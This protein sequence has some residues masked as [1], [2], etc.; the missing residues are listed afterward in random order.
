MKGGMLDIKPRI[1]IVDEESIMV[2]VCSK[3][4]CE[5][6]YETYTAL[7]SEEALKFLSMKSVDLVITGVNQIIMSGL[8]L[9]KIIREKYD[10]EVIIL[11]GYWPD[12][13]YEKAR[14]IA[15]F[16]LLYKPDRLH[17]L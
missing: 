7:H 12:G 16:E 9:T 3:Y 1:L 5:E 8:E 17:D 10:I 4:F 6:G 11:T 15:A 2:S 14:S 13:S